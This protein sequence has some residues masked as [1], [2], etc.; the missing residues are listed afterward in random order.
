MKYYNNERIKSNL[1]KNE[2][3]KISSSLLS[4]LSLNLSKLL[5][6]VQIFI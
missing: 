3:D 1:N 5:C 4:K 2:P 6:A